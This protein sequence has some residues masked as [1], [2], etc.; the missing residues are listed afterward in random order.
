VKILSFPTEQQVA[1]RVDTDAV[2][3]CFEPAVLDHQF[4]GLQFLG[5][6]ERGDGE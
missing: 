5:H 1:F 4:L 2:G 6:H 3:A